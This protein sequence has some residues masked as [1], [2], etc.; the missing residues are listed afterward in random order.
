MEESILAVAGEGEGH[1]AFASALLASGTAVAV[2]G[3]A[4][5]HRAAA[6]P[7]PVGVF[8]T[9]LAAAGALGAIAVVGGALGAGAVLHA[10]AAL[11]VALATVETLVLPHP[12]ALPDEAGER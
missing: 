3:T 5:V 8:A 7:I 12:D 1:G 6:R 2:V 9:R 10:V 4:L 11:A